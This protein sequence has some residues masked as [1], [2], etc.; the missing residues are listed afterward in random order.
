MSQQRHVAIVVGILDNM[1][2]QEKQGLLRLCCHSHKPSRQR[3]CHVG[4]TELLRLLHSTMFFQIWVFFKSGSTSLML[5]GNAANRQILLRP[6]HMFY[7][8][9]LKLLS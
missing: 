7:C 1:S 2:L 6:L 5:Q 3:V 8:F 9:N 4:P